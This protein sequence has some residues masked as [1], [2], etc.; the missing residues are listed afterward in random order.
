MKVKFPEKDIIEIEKKYS[1]LIKKYPEYTN[2]CPALLLKDKT[3]LKHCMNPQILKFVKQLLGNDFAL[4]NSSFFAKPARNGFE[5]PW[6]QDGQYWP[7]A[8][9]ATCTV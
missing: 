1:E 4:W 2:Y 5:T 9:L 3:F 7:I 8:P 6:H